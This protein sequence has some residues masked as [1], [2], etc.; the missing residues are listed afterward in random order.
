MENIKILID[1]E[2]INKRLDEMAKEIEEAYHGKD[3]V[4][5]GVLKGSVPFMWELS[6]RIKKNVTFEFIEVS[7]YVG[8][9][10]T[11]DVVLKKDVSNIEGKDVIVI[12][13]II[14]TG[15]TLKYLMKHLEEKKPASLKIAALLSKEIRRKVEIEPDFLGFDIEDKF[16]VGY[17]LDYDQNY[18]NLP[19]V[20]YI[21]N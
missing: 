21:E 12:E 13:D 18:R 15:I 10:S 3:I 16:V 7:S 6:K 8:T 20:G 19:F 14:D 1:E 2:T 9:E 17:G 4:F 11:G 5:L